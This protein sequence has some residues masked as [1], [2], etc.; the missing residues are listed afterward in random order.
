MKQSKLFAPTL[1]DTPSDAEVISHQL[2]L[3]AGYIRQISA[4]IYSY[5][6]LANRVMEKIKTI[7]REELDA[8]DGSEMLLPALL[9]ADL[10]KESGRYE[11]YGEDLIKLKDRHERDFI[12]GPTHEETFAK[13]IS[14]EIKSYKKLPLML[15]QFQTKYR[16][17]KRPRFGLMRGREFIMK[18]AYTFHDSYESLDDSYDQIAQA[19]SNSFERCGLNFRSI[20]GDAGAM[21]GKDSV[22]FMALAEAGEDTVVY[23][24]QGEYAANL[25][26]ATSLYRK[27]PNTD[28]QLEMKEVDT[29]GT[30]TIADLA[31][32]LD[33]A[34]SVTLKS[35][36]FVA[37]Q[38]TPVLAVVRGDQEVNDV[39]LRIALGAE[40]VEPAE[41]GQIQSL[42]KSTP[43]Y[44]GPVGI[45]EDVRIIADLHVQDV[46]NGVTG[47]N[48]EDKH[49]INVNPGR[50]FK[51]ENYADI[52]VVKQGDP[53][54]D[55]KGSLQF[56]K[57]IE[58]GHIFKLGTRYSDAMKATVL[59]NNGR[60]T[61]VIMGSY[62]IGV[63]R[64][65]S[66]IAEQHADEKGLVWPA[67]VAPF[68]V[69]IIPVQ[70]KNDEQ[71][72]AALGLYDKLKQKG[73]AALIDDRNERPGVKFKD[74]ELIG[75]PV[76]LTVGKKAS[77]G[78][79]EVTIRK[80]GE[81]IEARI[82]EVL[83]T[84]DILMQGQK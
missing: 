58:I 55:G 67:S 48:R 57:G 49:L 54:P 79:V 33:V 11:T 80:T 77:E 12:L 10:W 69:H 61:P 39:K 45:S 15:Y 26:M 8:I 71:R 36:L 22:E 70:M 1:R 32:F 76:Q 82:D 43:G 29:P 50:D 38:T 72:E 64:L 18:D 66:A 28:V 84:I 17:E 52:R 13:L 5:L 63:S 27:I 41:D 30:Q 37:D 65:L 16:D 78:I 68:D 59:D 47:A 60:Q 73:Y 19:Y 24:D 3:R 23:S 25:E 51:V 74:A 46:V 62:G 81:M 14:E 31:A 35:V 21:G 2:L 53:S 9:P 42:F 56:T 83:D 6:P 44:V 75:L 20:I 34:P 7:I 40:D 4:G